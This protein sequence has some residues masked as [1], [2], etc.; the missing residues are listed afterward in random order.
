MRFDEVPRIGPVVSL[1]ETPDNPL[2]VSLFHRLRARRQQLQSRGRPVAETCQAV[3]LSS[4][5][6]HPDPAKPCI[7]GVL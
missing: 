2:S 1:G 5:S 6:Q 4:T 7:C 3:P